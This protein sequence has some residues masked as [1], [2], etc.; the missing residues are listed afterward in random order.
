MKKFYSDIVKFTRRLV[1]TPSQNGVDSEKRVADL[2]FKE[3]SSFGF[4][5]KKI[6]NKNHPSVF[7]KII[8][9]PKRKAVWFE[10]CLD[11]VL[12]GD[13][14]KWR[15]PPL[16]ATISDS[17]MYGRGVAD[18]KIGIAIFCYLA[19]ELY[20]NPEFKGNII[21]GFDA[22]E[23]GGE[24]MG[25]RDVLKQKPKADVCI[26]G[27][28]GIEEISIGARGWLR[29]KITTKGEAAHTG[30]RF[31]KGNN[32]IHQMADIVT[33]LKKLNLGGRKKPYF[34]YGSSFNVSLIKG[35]VAINMVPDACEAKVDI[36]FLPSQSTKELLD[37]IYKALRRLKQ[38]NPNLSYKIEIL[39]SE[40]TFLT[41]PKDEFVRLLQ[42]V[43]QKE[44]KRKIPLVSSGGGSVG[45]V[46]STLNVPIINGFGCKFDNVHAPNEWIDI[47]TIPKV[48]EIYRKAI[49]EFCAT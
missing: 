17:K 5:P 43:A 29:L 12:I 27:Y 2:V 10:S 30:S 38:E 4:S 1:E 11:T 41:Y 26:L 40:N 36:R 32:A 44:L 13:L 49:L 8:K 48:F 42:R 47:S 39:Q 19:K 7:C 21:L 31:K 9:N 14:T 34:N 16:R 20:N 18:S 37:K 35:G 3:L 23:Q 46:I 6:G 24:F 15:Y 22:D 33:A 45:N 28:Q 25:I